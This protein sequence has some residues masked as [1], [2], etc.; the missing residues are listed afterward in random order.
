MESPKPYL[1]AYCSQINFEALRNPSTSDLAA[2]QEGRTDTTRHPFKDKRDDA[3]TPASLGR[4]RDISQ[5]SS[6]CGLCRLIVKTVS[7][8]SRDV[9][10]KDMEDLICQAETTFYGIYRDPQ[11]KHYWVRRLSI[12][13]DHESPRRRS[14]YFA[15]QACDIGATDVNVNQSFVDPRADRN[16]MVF[17]GRRRPLQLDLTWVKRWIMICQSDHGD[18]CEKADAHLRNDTVEMIR[19]INVRDRNIHTFSSC[20]ISNYSFIALSYVWGHTQ[21][22]TL[23]TSKAMELAEAGALSADLLPRT[24]EDTIVLARALDIEWVWIDALCI[25]QDDKGDKKVQIGNMS[26][27]YSSAFLTVIAASATGANDGLPGLHPWTRSTEQEEVIVVPDAQP[28]SYKPVLPGFSL[29]TTLRPQSDATEHYL[30]HV[31]KF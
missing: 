20:H 1:C 17:G 26:R 3:H 28:S 25:L 24:I 21:N 31:S 29:M 18:V 15:F 10:I 14:I 6:T 4:L 2:I 16:M 8:Q 5:R 19:F 9:S 11:G 22:L 27:I 30:E 12:L 7:R 23:R 13:I